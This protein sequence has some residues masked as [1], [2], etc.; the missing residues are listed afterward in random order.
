MA[1]GEF[2]ES[3]WGQ[4]NLY[5]QMYIYTMHTYMYRCRN[6]STCICGLEEGRHPGISP[7]VLF[8]RTQEEINILIIITLRLHGCA[9][10]GHPGIPS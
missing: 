6:Y 2:H 4:H 8:W 9:L 3:I 7:P 10:G 5:I 1:L